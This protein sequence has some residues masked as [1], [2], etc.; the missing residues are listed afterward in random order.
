M[1]FL[2]RDPLFNGAIAVRV[3]QSSHS[4]N[5]VRDHR[6]LI[7]K[8]LEPKAFLG[9]IVRE[10]NYWKQ[11]KAHCTHVRFFCYLLIWTS[12]LSSVWVLPGTGPA[13]QRRSR[14]RGTLLGCGFSSTSGWVSR[15][16]CLFPFLPIKKME[17]YGLRGR[18]MGRRVVQTTKGFSSE[19]L[20]KSENGPKSQLRRKKRQKKAT[21]ISLRNKSDQAVDGSSVAWIPSR[22]QNRVWLWRQRG[23]LR[24]PHDRLL[25]FGPAPHPQG[26]LT[27]WYTQDHRF[28]CGAV[29]PPCLTDPQG[30]GTASGWLTQMGG[31]CQGL[32]NNSKLQ[33]QEISEISRNILNPWFMFLVGG[34]HNFWSTKF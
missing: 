2:L 12:G 5:S 26:P 34:K 29:L 25:R 9:S 33:W 6:R 32:K 21:Q 4:N 28:A 17:C 16:V 3:S 24:E 10:R 27:L 8:G 13:W 20:F 7:P 1:S 23:V 15:S 19:S 18:K 30:R 22:T 11:A 31:E 14:M